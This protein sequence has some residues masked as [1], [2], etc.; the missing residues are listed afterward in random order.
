MNTLRFNPIPEWNTSN[1]NKYF[2]GLSSFC[3]VVSSELERKEPL[4]MCE[5][6]SYM[7]ESTFIFASQ[8]IFDEIHCIDPYNGLEEFNDIS[9]RKWVDVEKEFKINTRYF[10]NIILHKEYC[11]DAVHKFKDKYF[12]LI[13]ID[14]RHTYSDVK[15]NIEL[16][17]PKCKSIIAG[18]DYQEEWPGVVKAVNEIFGAP[19]ML[20]E[21][22]TWMK[23]L[24]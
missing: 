16:F 1:S 12:D 23:R 24:T 14:A 19:D 20:F 6:G 18:H 8:L 21:D 2:N 17:L 7:G 3:Q 5:I 13:Y 9:D 22:G 4:I 10:N 11:E 15:A